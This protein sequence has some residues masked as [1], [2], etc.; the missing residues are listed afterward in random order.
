MYFR[1]RR[2]RTRDSGWGARIAPRILAVIVAVAA[3]ATGHVSGQ[4]AAP[5]S[6]VANV[7][8]F[9]ATGDGVTDDTAAVKQALAAALR[10]RGTIYFPPGT[11]LIG[12]T[13]TVTD[14]VAFVGSG[15]GS[16][17]ALKDGV[18]R[19]MIL[20]QGASPSGE[21]IGF[22]ASNLVLDGKQGGQLDGGLLQINSS[23]GF[24]VDHLWVR[25]GGRPGESRTQGVDGIAVAV[26]SPTNLVASRGVIMN[27]MIEATT[28]PGILWST[29]ATDGLISGNIIRGLRGNSQ[30]PCLAVSEG[31]NVTVSGNSVSGC[32]GSGISIANG[33]N[34]VAP[35]HAIIANNHAYGNGTGT[36]EGNGIQVVNAFPDR[37]VFVEITGNV[38]YD[39]RGA[40]DGYGILV[41]NV[42]HAIVSGNIVRNNKRSGIVLYNVSGAL[43]EGNYILGNN[44]L[45]TPEHSGIMLHQVSRVHVTGNLAFD[46]GPTPTQAY[47]LFFSGTRPSDRIFVTNNVLY[48]NK[49]GPWHGHATPTNTV[50]VAN[51]T[52]DDTH[53]A[54][55][56]G[57]PDGSL[58]LTANASAPAS[59]PESP[60]A[61]YVDVKYKGKMYRLPLYAK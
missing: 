24:V 34:N 50:F 16:V 15:W 3:G 36:V 1:V 33:G 5:S 51:R 41:Q 27:S 48:P 37:R 12:E 22:Q 4:P 11:Y 39:N 43:V 45:G 7:R 38:L 47:G 2:D 9:R 40:A 10:A 44:A 46:D 26:K 25:N 52:G 32:E 19:I 17:L 53:L 29:H 49:L 58:E 6:G 35:V 31:R 56:S 60:P 8:D 54:I 13:L 14:T 28:K 21:T 20:V 30:T 23:V 59:G 61:L 57:T 42:D 55:G 18:R